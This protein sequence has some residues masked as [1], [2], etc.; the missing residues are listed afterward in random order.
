MKVYNGYNNK[1]FNR[2]YKKFQKAAIMF[3][4]EEH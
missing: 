1:Y 3:G 4:M 2:N